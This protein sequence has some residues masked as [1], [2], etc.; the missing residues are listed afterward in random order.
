LQQ[1][2][3]QMGLLE[4]KVA[5]ITGGTS[6][7]GARTV[8]LFAEHGAKVVV[9]GRREAEGKAIASRLGSAV[10]FCRT[11]MRDESQVQALI[12][13]AIEHFGRLDCMF[14]NAGGGG[15]RAGGIADLDIEAFEQHLANNL[16][17]AMLGMK[18]A[19]RIM[20]VQRAGSIINTG[21]LAGHRVGYSTLPYSAAKA[22]LLHATRWTAN[23]L[24]PYCIRVNS[25]SPGGIA[26][27]SFAK[28]SG[29]SEE[30]AAKT[31]G[32]LSE[33]FATIQPIPR[34]GIPDDVANAAIFLAS[35]L[36]S[37][38]TGHDIVVDGGMGMGNDWPTYVALR[39]EIGRRVSV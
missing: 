37:F 36:S 4:G 23:E 9:A 12:E 34:A 18:H 11:D 1:E 21:S 17:T 39:T 31:I 16:R 24:G 25:I 2:D 13:Y 33:F 22:A 3:K 20:Q 7:I 14:N 32:P 27:G 15:P 10:G 5:I 19:A 28:G 30:D 35:D 8:E 38:I 29:V 26:T 6:G